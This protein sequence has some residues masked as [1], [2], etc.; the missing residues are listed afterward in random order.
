[1]DAD[2]ELEEEEEDDDDA[3]V[4]SLVEVLKYLCIVAF[5]TMINVLHVF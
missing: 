2:E 5:G 3:V 4:C 1:M